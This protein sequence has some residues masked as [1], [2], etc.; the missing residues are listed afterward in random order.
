MGN[1]V[2]VDWTTAIEINNDF[3][4]VERRHESEDQFRVIGTLKAAGTVYTQ[5]DYRH[6]DFDIAKPGVYYYRLRQVDYDDTYSRSEIRDVTVSVNN[7]SILIYPNPASDLI[8]IKMTVGEAMKVKVDLQDKLGRQI[9]EYSENFDIEEGTTIRPLDINLI[10]AGV[11][12]LNVYLGNEV[13][14]LRFTKVDR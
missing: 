10:P 2:Q 1:H 9:L 4:E 7:N 14:N 13:Y 8:N 11:Y 12:M 6:L 5:Q 3:F